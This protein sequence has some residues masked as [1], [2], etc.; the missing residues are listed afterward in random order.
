LEFNLTRWFRA[1]AFA[2]YRFTSDI[3]IYQTKADVLDGFNFGMTFKFGKL[4]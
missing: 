1:A 4:N 2:S 3:E